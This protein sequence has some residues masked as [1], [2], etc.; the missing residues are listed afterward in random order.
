[1]CNC[2]K[3]I[4][5]KIAENYGYEGF[6]VSE[7]ISGRTY[8]ELVYKEPFGRRTRQKSIKILHDY[9]PFCGKQYKAR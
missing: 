5:Q 1:M 9:C 2:I 7:I 6:I 4:E 8:S 3:E